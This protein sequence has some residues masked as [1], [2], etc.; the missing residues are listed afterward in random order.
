MTVI[1]Q[2]IV[3]C[4]SSLE[5]D[6]FLGNNLKQHKKNI[7]GVGWFYQ[8][9]YTK[10]L[11]SIGIKEFIWSEQY[12]IQLETKVT[13]VIKTCKLAVFWYIEAWWILL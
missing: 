13:P 3:V 8:Q 7:F 11:H 4:S 10:T 1:G 5:T 6:Q 12:T 9:Y 2:N